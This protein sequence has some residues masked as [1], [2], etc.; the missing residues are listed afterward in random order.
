MQQSRVEQRFHERLDAADSHQVRHRVATARPQVGQY[1][2]ASANP[3]E[4]VEFKRHVRGVRNRQQVQDGVRGTREC[5]GD[6]DGV[7][8]CF[9]SEYVGGLDAELDQV[10][11]R[12]ARALGIGALGT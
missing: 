6:G 3:R 9:A 8:E 10:Y 7:F 5:D 1:R 4:I 12:P 2:D 11:D